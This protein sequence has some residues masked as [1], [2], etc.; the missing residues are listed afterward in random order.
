MVLAWQLAVAEG[1]EGEVLGEVKPLV[2]VL[3]LASTKLTTQLDHMSHCN[4]TTGTN[5]SS[6]WTS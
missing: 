2:V 1:G 3:H 4:A 6:R 5:W